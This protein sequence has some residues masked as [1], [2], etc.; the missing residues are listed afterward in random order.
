MPSRWRALTVVLALV[1]ALSISVGAGSTSSFGSERPLMTTSDDSISSRADASIGRLPAGPKA[2]LAAT[3]E[4][5]SIKAPQLAVVVLAAMVALAIA[6]VGTRWRSHE[7][8]R[9]PR[10]LP[11]SA[12]SRRG[13]P[14]FA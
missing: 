5:R 3:R 13:P 6:A 1:A 2:I 12:L 11:A 7:A 8:L 4:V 10:V 14:F 9:S